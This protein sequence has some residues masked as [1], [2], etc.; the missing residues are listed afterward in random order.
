MAAST[1]LS[2][3]R[4]AGG[5]D[6]TTA[7]VTDQQRK[8]GESLLLLAAAMGKRPAGVTRMCAC[9]PRRGRD[10]EAMEDAE[11][12]LC[13]AFPRR[14]ARRAVTRLGNGHL[15]RWPGAEG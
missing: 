2:Q 4:S 6:A 10:N 5:G 9:G 13:A 15:T 12:G 11:C 1:G 14:R 3:K 8:A 7:S